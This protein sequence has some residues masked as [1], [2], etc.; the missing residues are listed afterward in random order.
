MTRHLI[1]PT[2]SPT[3]GVRTRLTGG[4]ACAISI[5]LSSILLGAC[6][7]GQ[8]VLD[9]VGLRA[10]TSHSQP[11]YR[12]MTDKDVLLANAALDRALERNLSGVAAKWRNRGNGN[13]GSVTPLQ[14]YRAS[15]GGYCREYEEEIVVGPDSEHYLATACRD[16]LGTW[17]PTN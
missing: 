2:H 17:Q 9:S 16:A 5:V 11:L 7:A 13:H 12:S 15:G 8:K 14:T 6:V 4:M 1:S 3:P 10:S